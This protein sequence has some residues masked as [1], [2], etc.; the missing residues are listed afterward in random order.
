MLNVDKVRNWLMEEKKD[1]K[2]EED[3]DDD[4]EQ[5]EEFY[6]TADMP[7][8]ISVYVRHIHNSMLKIIIT[9]FELSA[10]FSLDISRATLIN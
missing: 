1:E 4:E 3:D 5:E 6:L 8:S 2:E 9:S 10:K 7:A